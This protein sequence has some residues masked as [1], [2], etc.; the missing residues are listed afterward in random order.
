MTADQWLKWIVGPGW[1][2][3]GVMVNGVYKDG[4]SA[5]VEE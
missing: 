3:S 2:P 4:V 5:M 1:S